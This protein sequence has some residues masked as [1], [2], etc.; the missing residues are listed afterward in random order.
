MTLSDLPVR[1]FAD[2][3][4]SDAPAPGG[5]SAAALE[6]A[7]GAALTAMVSALTLG[8]KKFAE[9]EDFAKQLFAEMSELKSAFLDAMEE[10]N[11]V[12]T[13]FSETMALPKDTEEEKAV[14]TAAM[15]AA[16]A[17]CTRAPLK[18]MELSLQALKLTKTAIGRTNT[19]ASSDIGVAALSL[20]A[21][22]QGAW[23]NVRI[24]VGILK[25]T[26]LAEEFRA[27]G[28]ELL[29]DAT[30]LADE[31]YNEIEQSL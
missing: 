9:Y 7:L 10:D 1:G 26:A 5:G 3:L 23:L 15:Q 20:K 27:R 19:G 14:R 25:D 12:F 30:A 22:A 6:G 16:L 4:G 21:A 2:L 13:R 18:V 24:N 8:R 11:A 29:A 28:A 31:I 17:D